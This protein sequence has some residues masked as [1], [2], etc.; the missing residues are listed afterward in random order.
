MPEQVE[1]ALLKVPCVREARVYGVRNP[2]TGALVAADIVLAD[3]KP[4]EAARREIMQQLSASLES[5]K[6]PR[7]IR[8]V[9]AIS[10][11]AMG[12]KTRMP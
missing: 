10:I 3:A 1:S 12:K 11:N 4:E 5:H 2:L 6:L 7:I 8:F 9:A